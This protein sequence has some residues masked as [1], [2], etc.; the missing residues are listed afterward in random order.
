MIRIRPIVY[1]EDGADRDY[2]RQSRHDAGITAICSSPGRIGRLELR[3]RILM[4]PMGSNLAEE[5][6]S[7]G[8]R[9]LRYY[10]ARAQG[11]AAMVIMGS[12]GVAWPRGSG[13]QRQV[14][15]SE[16]RFIAPLSR[17]AAAVHAH[18]ARIAVQLQ[19]AGAIAVNEPF[20]GL[21]F[22]V[23]SVPEAK[24]IDWPVDLTADEKRDMFDK[25]FAPT[26]KIGYQE[27]TDE[28]IEW[29]LASFAASA[30]RARAAGIDGVEL[31]AGHGYIFS[32]FLSPSSNRRA[33]RYGGPLENRA[34][35]LVEAVRRVRAA[36]GDDYPVWCR[37]DSEEYLKTDGIS[38]D[39]AIETAKLVE[40]A[41]VDAVHVTAYADASK[42]IS[43][44]EAHTVAEPCKYVPNTAAI[45]AAV[46][47]PVIGVGRIEP[48]VADRLIAEGKLDFVAMAR[49]LLADPELPAKLAAGR[50]DLIRPCIYCYT[51]ISQIFLGSHTRCAVN[52]QTGF[53]AS[54][55]IVP[56]TVRKRVLVIGG[57]P[58]GMEAARVAALR[59]H[60]VELVEAG[61][62]L[63]GTVFF[64]SIVS[65]DNGPLIDYLAGQLE[66]L[67]VRVR[68]GTQAS[69][70]FVR[71]AAPDEVVVATGARR[72][73]I[74]IPGADLPHV[75][76]G[77][78]MREMV[79]GR[80][81]PTLARKLRAVAAA[82]ACG[83]AVEW[84]ARQRTDHSTPEPS[85][86]AARPPCR[87]ST[88]AAWSASSS[89]SSSP[90]AAAR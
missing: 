18:G 61:D 85:L 2:R 8:E 90:S 71:R 78:E 44:T 69:V 4:S 81:G 43:F 10:E 15:L 48:A 20:H 17:V 63:G 82:C 45:K 14:A 41:G 24:A 83:R 88:A 84:R 80:F 56:A 57:G 86:V 11:G 23:P 64:S 13:N 87:R 31:H 76:S 47:V 62:R 74:D 16:D 89:P 68:L 72:G 55:P 33:D 65:P 5:D 29:L 32:S 54:D 30:V 66:E 12:V 38:L 59:G 50:P 26:V 51:C 40:Q 79:T 37:L 77:D 52:A 49:K 36:V 3:N 21:P 25:F 9:I 60:A 35:L 58:A 1:S 34:R 75:L 6:G 27:A 19:H 39:D 42:G 46:R 7:C 28:D 70:E 53:E 73:L 22:L 67:G